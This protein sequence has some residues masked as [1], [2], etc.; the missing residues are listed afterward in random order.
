MYL[1]LIK[2]KE[3]GG[4]EDMKIIEVRWIQK[5]G[6]EGKG[7]WVRWNKVEVKKL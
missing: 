6:K 7:A 2:K 5:G 3:K 4:G 1:S